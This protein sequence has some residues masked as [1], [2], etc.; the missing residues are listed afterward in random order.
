M[1]GW[2]NWVKKVT[3]ASNK[4]AE[5]TAVGPASG[6]ITINVAPAISRRLGTLKMAGTPKSGPNASLHQPLIKMPA[7]NTAQP[8]T[9]RPYASGM[10]AC[11]RRSRRHASRPAAPR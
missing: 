7:R 2:S 4:A 10:R 11:G 1:Y 3:V 6:P 8:A 5:T 9:L